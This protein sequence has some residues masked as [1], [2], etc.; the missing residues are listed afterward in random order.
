V[1]GPE[2]PGEAEIADTIV[3]YFDFFNISTV[4]LDNELAFDGSGSSDHYSFQAL[5]SIP[6]SGLFTGA[7]TVKTPELAELFG[8]I[9]GEDLDPC[10]HKSCDRMEHISQEILDEM[11]DATAHAILTFANAKDLP[12]NSRYRRTKE[13]KKAVS[14]RTTKRRR[15]NR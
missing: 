12:S 7:D 11:S 1:Y 6:S 9:V 10:Y 8:G 5:G 13:A 2:F 3:S 4:P 14:R 15:T